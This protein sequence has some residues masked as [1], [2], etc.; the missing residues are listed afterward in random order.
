MMLDTITHPFFEA[1]PAIVPAFN[2]LKE[3]SMSVAA[4]CR[5]S[6]MVNPP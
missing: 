4:S 1:R 6:A 5:S 2:R 3:G